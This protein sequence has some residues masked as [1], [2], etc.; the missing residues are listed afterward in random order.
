MFFNKEL[1]ALD[2]KL[3]YNSGA[4]VESIPIGIYPSKTGQRTSSFPEN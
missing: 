2:V 3:L 1:T 4:G